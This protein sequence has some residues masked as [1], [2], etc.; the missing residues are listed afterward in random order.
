M[1]YA[2]GQKVWF[3]PR[4]SRTG[5]GRE[6]VV[7]SVGRKWVQLRAGHND[8]KVE[9]GKVDV[10][11]GQ[12]SSPGVLYVSEQAYHDYIALSVAWVKLARVFVCITRPPPDVSMDD[13]QAAAVLL[14]VAL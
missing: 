12:Y 11:G 10:D 6:L 5:T 2:V 4:D 13:I 8:F 1:E 3:V 14:K 9:I 7:T